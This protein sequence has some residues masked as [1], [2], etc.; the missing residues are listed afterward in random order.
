MVESFNDVKFKLEEL[1][2]EEK[3]KRGILGR[4]VG[5]CASIS[6]PTR[7]GRLYCEDLWDYQFENNEILR[8]LIQNGGVP[9]EL[10][11]P[12]DRD[13]TCSEKIAAMMP[14]LPKKDKDGHL[15][16]VVDI[17]DTPMGKIA[18]QLAK[19]GFNLGISSRGN[20]DVYT[21][22]DGNEAV[23]P[24]TYDLQTFDLVLVPAV[25]DARLNLIEGLQPD[26]QKQLRKALRESLSQANE[27][28]RKVMKETLRH[29][30]INLT[31]PRKK[32][33][34]DINTSNSEDIKTKSSNS[35]VETKKVEVK[36]NESTRLANQL[37]EAL[38][39]KIITE[40]QLQ[41]LQEQLAVSDTKVKKLEE[42]NSKY[43]KATMNLSKQVQECKG[44]NEENQK[45]KE[46]LE[47]KDKMIKA[48]NGKVKLLNENIEK[49]SQSTKTLT[50]SVSTNKQ[51]LLKLREN[52]LLEKKSHK[53]EVSSLNEK[54]SQVK[55]DYDLKLNESN[56][57][58]NKSLKLTE[59]YKNFVNATVDRYIE[60]KAIMLGIT[61][62]E[63]KNR[64][65][66]S[67][68]LDD[69]D[70]ICEDLQNY[71]LRM[72]R[73]PF[74]VPSGTRVAIQQVQKPQTKTTRQEDD[75]DT[76]GLISL[77]NRI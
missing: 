77:M 37:K 15:V 69:I 48:L 32:I 22:E 75:D 10:D 23:D 71:N 24:E 36:D 43:K 20:G 41:G 18:Y 47:T 9:M 61:S 7:N 16:C 27:T 76:S 1:T 70:K 5:P 59:K 17:I 39:S 67:Y 12:A 45:L 64:L 49:K 44:L 2:P 26:N 19:Y 72:S 54:L 35:S 50:E 34:E 21:D 58:L 74:N 11:H 6:I 4:L 30:G 63:I 60:S 55:K 65:S 14:E 57:K 31:T 33:N 8:E 46:Q 29:L 62:N 51:E 52:L 25:K 28:D 13:E 73:L 42:E 56:A 66:E 38:K 3:E 68:T 53:D 40:R